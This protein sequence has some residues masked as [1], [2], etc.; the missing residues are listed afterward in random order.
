MNRRTFVTRIAALTGAAL[1]AGVCSATSY[2]RLVGPAWAQP[3]R[4]PRFLLAT[5][6]DEI[7]GRLTAQ[8]WAREAFAEL[9]RTADGLTRALPPVPE[10]GGGWFH[11]GGE[12]YEVTR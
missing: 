2:V 12:A 9:K 11:A 10:Q 3:G 5:D 7:R 1:A 4:G 8:P 6:L